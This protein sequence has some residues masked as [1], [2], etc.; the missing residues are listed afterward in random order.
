M[1]T[2]GDCVWEEQHIWN[3]PGG[4]KK[5]I[6]GVVAV[7][8]LGGIGDAVSMVPLQEEIRPYAATSGETI[9]WSVPIRLGQMVK[10]ESMRIYTLAEM[11]KH[12]QIETEK[13]TEISVIMPQEEVA[14]PVETVQNQAIQPVIPETMPE[15][16]VNTLPEEDVIQEESPIEA[17]R[18]Y[19]GFKIDQ[20]GMI[21]GFDP[22]KSEMTDGYLELPSENCIGI[23]RG[24]FSGV[25]IGIFEIYIPENIQNIENG[26][27]SELGEL[28]WI[29][30]GGTDGYTARD[31]ILFSGTE[32]AAFPAGR[33]GIFEMPKDVTAIRASAFANTN[34]DKIDMRN[35]ISI[36][37]DEGIFG[38]G[39]GCEIM[40]GKNGL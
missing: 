10:Q 12:V 19:Q 16:I 5:V 25:G 6:A 26:A 28:T 17:Y 8:L 21:C 14:E 11:E 24:T 3:I 30:A 15:E 7:S 38:G 22:A 23:R 13:A 9:R 27:F 40:E 36:L 39:A 34:L 31:G 20:E 29:E 2:S 18:Y 1:R 37:Y 35:C 33:T 32:L 4:L